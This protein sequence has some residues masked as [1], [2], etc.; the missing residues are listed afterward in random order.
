MNPR[1][2]GRIK[3]RLQ[4][5]CGA[6]KQTFSNSFFEELTIVTNALDNVEARRYVDSRC[7]EN[8]VPLLESGTLSSKGHVQVIIPYKTQS[9]GSKQD[10]NDANG[11]VPQCTLKM[12]P[13]ETLHCV[14]WARDLFGRDFTLAPKALAKLLEAGGSFTPTPSDLQMLKDCVRMLESRPTNF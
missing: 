7:V 14:E 12:F 10:P 2:K 9:Y 6:T 4:K 5:V 8:K 3:A 1:L 13:E 11:E